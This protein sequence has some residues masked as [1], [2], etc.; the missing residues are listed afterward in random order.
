MKLRKIVFVVLGAIVVYVLAGTIYYSGKYRAYSE[1]NP[2]TSE[3]QPDPIYVSKEQELLNLTNAERQK[4][5]VSPLVMDEALNRSAQHKADRMVAEGTLSHIDSDGVHGYEYISLETSDCKQV[6]EN[7][8]PT[9]WPPAALGTWMNS[10]AH[11]EAI[12]DA[13]YD[14]VGFGIAG[15]YTVQHFC[16][17]D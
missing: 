17:I 9:N 12:L 8:T 4:A 16:S 11:R 13:K 15:N 2:Q 7:L 10:E 6:S 1:T 14:Y 3:V 5:G